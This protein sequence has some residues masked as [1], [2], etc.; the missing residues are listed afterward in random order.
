MPWYVQAGTWPVPFLPLAFRIPCM[1]V[2]G[3][4][5]MGW[6]QN[7]LDPSRFAGRR[8][9][10]P[11]LTFARWQGHIQELEENACLR[12]ARECGSS[13]EEVNDDPARLAARRERLI[14]A[15]RLANIENLTRGFRGG[16]F[17]E[18]SLLASVSPPCCTLALPTRAIALNPHPHH[19]RLQ[20]S[21]LTLTASP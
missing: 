18:W 3:P 19:P 15:A 13:R 11:R 5:P 2:E 20:P 6:P 14:A 9:T 7:Q 12:C 21:P 16:G 1:R 17:S 10:H 8:G 4:L